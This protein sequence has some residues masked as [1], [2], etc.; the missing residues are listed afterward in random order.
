MSV[1]NYKLYTILPFTIISLKYNSCTCF[2]KIKL[3][4]L[5]SCHAFIYFVMILSLTVDCK[6]IHKENN[7]QVIIQWLQVMLNIWP[8]LQEP[9]L[10]LDNYFSLHGKKFL[11]M[12]GHFSFFCHGPWV[13]AGAVRWK[14]IEIVQNLSEIAHICFLETSGYSILSRTKRGP[15]RN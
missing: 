13:S 10:E 2:F 11:F 14:A 3:H 6:V 4:K 7:N 9:C 1:T 15:E 5:N 8:F 12:K